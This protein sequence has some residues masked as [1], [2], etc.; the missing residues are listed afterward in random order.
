ME[1]VPSPLLKISHMIVLSGLVILLS[2]TVTEEEGY[3]LLENVD[4][5]ASLDV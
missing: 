2:V 5:I 4:A 1:Y 3:S